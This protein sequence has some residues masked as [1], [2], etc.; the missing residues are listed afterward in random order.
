VSAGLKEFRENP[1]RAIFVTGEIDERLVHRLMPEI[2]RLRGESGDPITAYIDSRGGSTL[3]T[4]HIR[5]LCKAPNQDG[6][7]CSLVTV[8]TTRAASAAADLLALGDYAIAYPKSIIHCHGTRLSA[9]EITKESAES[10]AASL[11]E[12]NEDF[13]LRLA[14]RVFARM[15]FR[16]T[17]LRH[18]FPDIRKEASEKEWKRPMESDLECFALTIFQRLSQHLQKLPQ[19]VFFLY[20]S[21]LKMRSFVLDRLGKIPDGQKLA[22]TEASMLKHLLDF[23]LAQ[24]KPSHWSFSLGGFDLFA[25]DFRKLADFLFGKH[26]G[27]LDNHI[28]TLGVL[29]LDPQQLKVHEKIRS[30]NQ[31][32]AGEWLKTAVRPTIEPLW[33]FTVA[34]C[35]LLQQG[36]NQ[37]SAEDA[38]WLGLADEVVGAHLPSLRLVAENP[39]V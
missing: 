21:L 30:E 16:Y 28:Q 37:L 6:V 35:R 23:E 33:Y 15:A 26:H 9:E 12:A 19:E 5:A 25:S 34:L 24:E 18:E 22:V 29:F 10:L 27:A 13:A 39:D 17:L 32:A 8:A 20:E 36:E 2:C 1:A 4:E 3:S 38:Y 14:K 11:H 31:S 7:T